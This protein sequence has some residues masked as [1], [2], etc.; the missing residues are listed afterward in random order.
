MRII[1]V[2]ESENPGARQTEEMLFEALTVR[3]S[4]TPPP[5]H[6]RP[7]HHGYGHLI[8]VHPLKLR[9]VVDNLVSRESQEI[10]EHNLA[11]RPFA[12]ECKPVGNTHNGRFANRRI[13]NS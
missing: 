2:M 5:A 13:A 4:I 6:G 1:L 10:S 12:G 7:Y 8:V 3:R 11:H 9:G